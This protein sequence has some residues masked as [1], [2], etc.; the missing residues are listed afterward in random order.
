MPASLFSESGRRLSRSPQ[1]IRAS[2]AGRLPDD[3]KKPA[4]PLLQKSGRDA[5]HPGIDLSVDCLTRIPCRRL[6]GKYLAPATP[7]GS[8][9]S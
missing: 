6:F 5:D 7:V 3:S 1:A 2:R 9:Q 4:S 8:K